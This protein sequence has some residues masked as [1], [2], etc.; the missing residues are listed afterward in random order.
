MSVYPASGEAEEWRSTGAWMGVA[1]LAGLGCALAGHQILHGWMAPSL[2]LSG[3]MFAA[4]L[5]LTGLG[6][7]GLMLLAA[8]GGGMLAWQQRG[9]VE[10]AAEGVRRTYAPGR[11]RFAARPEIAG[12]RPRIG[13]G[14]DLVNVADKRLFSIPRSISGYRECLAELRE[15]GIPGLPTKPSSL[16]A[17]WKPKG[18]KERIQWGGLWCEAILLGTPGDL[19]GHLFGLLI[20]LA[21]LGWIA[22]DNRNEADPKRRGRWKNSLF[23]VSLYTVGYLVM[24][25]AIVPLF[26]GHR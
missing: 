15:M 3:K 24:G 8:L 7:A 18:W 26:H 14:I 1:G 20:V 22:V 13:G 12:Y 5:E 10:V 23:A 19:R 6:L 16:V 21:W 25:Y 11:C 4:W 2:E 17:G 9:G